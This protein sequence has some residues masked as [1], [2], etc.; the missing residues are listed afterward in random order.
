MR[1]LGDVE[2]RD[3]VDERIEGKR[4]LEE[5][6]D[7]EVPAGAD[8]QRVAVGGRFH[9]VFDGDIARCAR[10]VLDHHLPAELA[11]EAL[12]SYTPED[13]GQPARGGIHDH[14]DRAVRIGVLRGGGRG[15]CAQSEA[16]KA[17]GCDP[18]GIARRQTH[19]QSIRMFALFTIAA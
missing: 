3:Q 9:H 17:R 6:L 7:D 8:Q 15:A 18:A 19:R 2:H 5:R 14:P 12:G 1:R 10:L 16:D 11:R 13:I 4:V